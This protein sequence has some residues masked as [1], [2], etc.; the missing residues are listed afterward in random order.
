MNQRAEQI[1]RCM[2]EVL[3]DNLDNFASATSKIESFHAVNSP[4]WLPLLLNCLL[5]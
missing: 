2:W 5:Y 3:T 1:A 4:E